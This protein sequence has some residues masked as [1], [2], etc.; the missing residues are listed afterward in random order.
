MSLK[1]NVIF[2]LDEWKPAGEM[3]AKLLK[4]LQARCPR[5]H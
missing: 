1:Q 5:L 2:V 4:I 3:T